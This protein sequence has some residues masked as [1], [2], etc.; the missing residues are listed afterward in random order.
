MCFRWILGV[1]LLIAQSGLGAVVKGPILLPENAAPELQLAAKE[2]VTHIKLMTGEELSTAVDK[3]GE[4]VE[5]AIRLTV[6]AKAPGIPPADGSDQASVIDQSGRGVLIEGQSPVGTLY[7]AYEYLGDL[8]VRW[9]VPGELGT[10][11]PKRPAIETTGQKKQVTPGF[12][13][14]MVWLSGDVGWHWDPAKSKELLADYNYWQVRNRLQMAEKRLQPELANLNIDVREHTGHNI[15]VIYKWKKLTLANAPE[16]FPLVTRN[17]KQERYD[18]G[19][20]CFTHP[21]NI[22]DAAAWC[23]DFFD[24]DPGAMRASMSLSDTGGICECDTCR[25][26]NGGVDPARDGN[27]L[28]WGFMNEVARRVGQ[29][30]PGKGIAFYSGYGAT[31]APPEGVKSEPNIVGCVAHIAHNSCD[32]EDK[33]C[34]FNVAHLQKFAALKATGA[35]MMARDYIMYSSNLQPLVILDYIKTYKKLGCVGYSCEVMSRSEQSMMVGWAQAQL[36]WNP[37]LDPKKLIEE[38]CLTYFGPAGADVLATVNAIDDSVKKVPRITIGGFG[39]AN[40]IMTDDLN[41]FGRKTL[42]DAAGKVDGVYKQRLERFTESFEVYARLAEAYRALFIAL[43]D[44]RPETQQAA[45][46][47]FDS[48]IAYYNDNYVAESVSPHII[49]AWVTRVRN[50]A[51]NLP[52]IKPALHKALVGLDEE[53]LKREVF[54]LDTL[55]AKLENFTMLGNL[56]KFRQDIYNRG[57][58][59]G[60][61]GETFDDSKWPQLMYGFFDEQGF[62]RVEGTY[63]YRNTFQPPAVPAGKR[64]IMRIGGLDDEGKIFI[65]GKLAHH[66]EGID[67][68]DWKQSFEFDITEFVKPGAKNTI[69]IEGR[70]DYGKGG[71]HK[72]VAVYVREHEVKP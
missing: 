2:L 38:Y 66:R 49:P 21:D 55:P 13:S 50:T 4:L 43:D 7:G 62:Q 71:L 15:R 33:S 57:E 28:V 35:E 9:F 46:A 61:A 11:V 30:K 32:L 65:N 25:K 58:A 18:K 31:S 16:R 22:A 42:A 59:S 70:N 19:Q 56:W 60:W 1:V 40:E 27:R 17:G 6:N 68:D 26:A 3:G 69:A 10:H 45:V 48:V 39:S 8:G 67:G 53:G 20:I 12:R 47:K 72:P 24:K 5:G 23:I 34:N 41:A 44:R 54:T 14:R 51:V 63:W 52:P 64:L 29:A 36:T 37:S